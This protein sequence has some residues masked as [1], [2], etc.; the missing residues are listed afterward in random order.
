M[1]DASNKPL[2]SRLAVRSNNEIAEQGTKL[3]QEL[4]RGL[5]DMLKE[6]L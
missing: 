3:W 6:Y 1:G 2:E 5:F 4:R